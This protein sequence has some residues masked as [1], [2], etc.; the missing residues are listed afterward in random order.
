MNEMTPAEIVMAFRI[1]NTFPARVQ[2]MLPATDAE[3][4]QTVYKTMETFKLSVDVAFQW[5]R[6][7]LLHLAEEGE[8]DDYEVRLTQHRIKVLW[9]KEVAV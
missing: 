7:G 9:G 2:E 6:D 3:L 1:R 4:I 5:V 8:M